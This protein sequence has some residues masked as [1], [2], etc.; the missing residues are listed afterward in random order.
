MQA[1]L[2]ATTQRAV[3]ALGLTHGPIHAEM[4]HNEQG[5]WMLEVAG[6]P[7]GGLCARALR[8]D[9]GVAFEEVLLRFAAGE[10]SAQSSVR[11]APPV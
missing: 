8:F 5:V 9:G 6:R 4:R 10:T 7:I 1:D 3:T 2:I 11:S